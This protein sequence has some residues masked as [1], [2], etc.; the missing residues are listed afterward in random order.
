M[1]GKDLIKWIIDN[2]AENCE[3]KKV[4]DRGRFPE[5]YKIIPKIRDD[6]YSTWKDNKPIKHT[7]KY[8]IFDYDCD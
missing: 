8:I 4:D 6:S 3:L 5:Y 1:K 2:H 7:R